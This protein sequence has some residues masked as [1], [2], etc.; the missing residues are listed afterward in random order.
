MKLDETS[1]NIAFNLN[2][3]PEEPVSVEVVPVEKTVSVSETEN[4]QIE[5]KVSESL[6]NV[7]DKKI[8]EELDY[9]KKTQMELIEKAKA[10]FDASVEIAVLSQHPNSISAASSVLSSITNATDLIA[11]INL[12]IIKMK[13]SLL[14]KKD[15]SNINIDKAVFVGSTAELQKMLKNNTE[16]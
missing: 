2:T 16:K 5:S 3:E 9:A 14:S 7:D 15:S 4:T 1:L 10:L 11:K 12:N 8:L 13:S 6:S